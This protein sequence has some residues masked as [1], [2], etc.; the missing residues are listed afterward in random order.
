MTDSDMSDC[1]Q[2][3]LYDRRGDGIPEGWGCDAAGKLSTDP[4]RV[5]QGG[6]LVPI[7]GSEATGQSADQ[8]HPAQTGRDVKPSV[9][10]L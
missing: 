1:V 10:M 5:L 4:K 9:G 7:G 6:G 2:V 8:W 3:E